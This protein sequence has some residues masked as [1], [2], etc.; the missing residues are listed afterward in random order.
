VP[1]KEK[2]PAGYIGE[3]FVPSGEVGEEED[4]LLPRRKVRYGAMVPE[5]EKKT[6]E[7]P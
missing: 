1:V 3:M 5:Y 2:Q 6:W 4:S 7:V